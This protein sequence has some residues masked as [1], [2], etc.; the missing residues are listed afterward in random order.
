ME[1]ELPIWDKI[2][3]LPHFTEV[4]RIIGYAGLTYRS[5]MKKVEPL[6]EK[7][8]GEA[9][10]TAINQLASFEGKYTS[11][12]NPLA[13]VCLREQ[14]RHLVFML[15][16][17]PPEKEAEFYRHADGTPWYPEWKKPPTDERQ[18]SMPKTSKPA[19]KNKPRQDR[20]ADLPLMRQYLE[21]KEQHPGML[22]AFRRG[23]CYELYEEDADA[24]AKVLNL[25][26]TTRE[27]IR[28]VWFP[29]DALEHQLERLLKAGHRVAVCD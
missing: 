25:K 19:R 27:A 9:I 22:L 4:A 20:D 5:L 11:E 24:A 1:K 10:N 29:I 23:N 28:T 12:V 17:P 16:G 14:V 18:E 6:R 26:P 8:G 21:A 3:F 7:F 2:Y 15:L 13:H